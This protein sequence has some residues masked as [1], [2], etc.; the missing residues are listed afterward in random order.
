MTTGWKQV[1]RD[2]VWA[3]NW[4]PTMLGLFPFN[5][6]ERIKIGFFKEETYAFIGAQIFEMGLSKQIFSS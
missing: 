6:K 2:N 4:G 1:Y 3:G 5:L